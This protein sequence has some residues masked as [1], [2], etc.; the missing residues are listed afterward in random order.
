MDGQ[1]S[2]P[3]T[4]HPSY[5]GSCHTDDN[6]RSWLFATLSEPLLEKIHALP[7]AKPVCEALQT[8]YTNRSRA[9]TLEIR[10]ALSCDKLTT[11]GME[12][13]RCDIKAMVDQLKEVNSP[14][15]K[16]DLVAYTLVGLPWEYGAFATSITNGCDT[17]TFDESR[18]KLIHQEHQEHRLQQFHSYNPSDITTAF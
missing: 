15:S 1:F 2:C 12:A 7:S 9:W 5:L 10:L 17:I 3:S 8:H 18:T 4:T 11:Q 14:I 13:H 6:I 16:E